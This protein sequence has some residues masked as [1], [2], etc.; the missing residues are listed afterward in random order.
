MPRP[1]SSKRSRVP[2]TGDCDD[3]V[4]SIHPAPPEICDELE[5]DCDTIID[6]P[7]AIDAQVF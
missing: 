7:D 6:G 5:N 4:D 2:Q 3:T 1:E